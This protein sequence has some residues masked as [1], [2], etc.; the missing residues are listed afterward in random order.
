MDPSAPR[1]GADRAAD[2]T[3]RV[4]R[5]RRRRG[6]C[7][8]ARRDR[9][10]IAG[11]AIVAVPAPL[12]PR[13]RGAGADARSARARGA[14][15]SRVRRRRRARRARRE[16]DALARTGE[17]RPVGEPA[18]PRAPLPAGERLRPAARRLPSRPPASAAALTEAVAPHAAPRG[19]APPPA[20]SSTPVRATLGRRHRR[21]VA[22]RGRAGS[23]YAFRTRLLAGLPEPPRC[24]SPHRAGCH[25]SGG[26]SAVGSPPAPA[27][28][29]SGAVPGGA[30]PG[31]AVRV[32]VT[33]GAGFIGR[34]W[35]TPARPRRRAGSSTISCPRS[36]VRRVRG[37]W[38]RRRR[39]R[40]RRRRFASA[41]PPGPPPRARS[42][43]AVAAPPSTPG[44]VAATVAVLDPCGHRARRVSPT[45]RS[46]TSLAADPRGL[47]DRPALALRPSPRRPRPR[48]VRRGMAVTPASRVRL[49][50]RG[51]IA[52]GPR[53]RDLR[54][55]LRRLR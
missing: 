17:A 12:P 28:A 15:V 1:P 54:R 53:R 10:A 14:S 37:E 18:A 42:T 22:W 36:W 32:L 39:P 45:A 7:P 52:T 41:R 2:P 27:A 35:S 26:R 29:R 24:R 46:G 31:S 4:S 44:H 16:P 50:T 20:W 48:A 30:P 43:S 6:P 47:A 34:T 21:G 38:P 23:P 19:R 5:P 3:A 8:A 13:A 25:W 51:R 49:S 40:P 9:R 55:C 33:G 11:L